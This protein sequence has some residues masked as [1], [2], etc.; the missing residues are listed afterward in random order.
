M[1]LFRFLFFCFVS[2]SVINEAAIAAPA[3]ITA[4]TAAVAPKLNN[5]DGK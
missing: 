1:L 2:L 3:A 4:I 5:T